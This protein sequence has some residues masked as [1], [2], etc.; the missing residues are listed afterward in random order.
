M[1]ESHARTKETVGMTAQRLGFN[2]ESLGM[3]T[4]SSN[5]VSASKFGS[6]FTAFLALTAKQNKTCDAFGLWEHLHSLPME[7]N[8][9]SLFKLWR[10]QS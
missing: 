1:S 4:Q 6:I 7:S 8:Q 10:N 9:V 5:C 2:L 3:F